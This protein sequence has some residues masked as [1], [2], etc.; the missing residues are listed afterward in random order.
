MQH[1]GGYFHHS[2]TKVFEHA[3]ELYCEIEAL[4]HVI[5]VKKKSLR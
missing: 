1:H 2:K 3:W 4:N 5:L